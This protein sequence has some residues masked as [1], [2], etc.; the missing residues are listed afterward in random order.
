MARKEKHEMA[1]VAKHEIEDNE[2]LPRA[3]EYQYDAQKM[4]IKV[5]VV[6]DA[7]ALIY[8]D[9]AGAPMVAG[10]TEGS[11]NLATVTAEAIRAAAEPQE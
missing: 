8:K 7:G 1:R 9:R 4:R 6:E 10:L 2:E 5:T 3:V 11:S